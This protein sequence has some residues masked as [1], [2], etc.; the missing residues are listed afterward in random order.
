M[1]LKTGTLSDTYF[2]LVRAF[3]LTRIRDDVHLAE[4]QAVL[5]RLLR[6]DL[7]AGGQDY[8]DVL[9]DLV[10][11]YEDEH[12][13]FPR[14]DE[15]DVLRELMRGHGLTQ[16][17]LSG[18]VGIAQ[19]TLSAVLNRTRSLTKGQVVKLAKFFAVH[20]SAFLHE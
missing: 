5:D 7:D 19:S 18:A 20:P 10:E 9:T 14:V 6:Q 3:P 15:A 16:T 1:A 17:K 13:E 4:A 8:L 12:V 2:K 11:G